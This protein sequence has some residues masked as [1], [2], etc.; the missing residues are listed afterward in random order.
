MWCDRNNQLER[1]YQKKL[2]AS[3]HEMRTLRNK[4]EASLEFLKQ[5]HNIAAAK[6]RRVCLSVHLCL[7]LP[8][9]LPVCVSV[10]LSASV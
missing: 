8:S 4:T 3:E 9:C 1:S 2:E 6:V 10:Y 5:E 7:S